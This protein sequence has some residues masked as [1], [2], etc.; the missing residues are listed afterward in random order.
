MSRRGGVFCI[1]G[2]VIS[3]PLANIVLNLIQ[4]VSDTP[5]IYNL[6]PSPKLSQCTAS[7]TLYGNY[8]S[9]PE[10]RRRLGTYLVSSRA[11]IAIYRSMSAPLEYSS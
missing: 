9:C 7:N 10:L 6:C 3:L 11:P 4:P 8:T 2:R 5:T 1:G